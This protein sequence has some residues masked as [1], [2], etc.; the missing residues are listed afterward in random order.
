MQCSFDSSSNDLEYLLITYSTPLNSAA[1]SK[2]LDG[3]WTYS[4]GPRQVLHYA[5]FRQS[6]RPSVTKASRRRAE[7][8]RAQ[9]RAGRGRSIEEGPSRREAL[10]ALDARRQKV[11][12][13]PAPRHPA[14]SR[15]CRVKNRLS[16]RSRTAG[17]QEE[18]R[19]GQGWSHAGDQAGWANI[20]VRIRPNLT[21]P[22]S[23]AVQANGSKRAE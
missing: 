15:Q 19:T 22:G 10:D 16:R 5:P 18:L 17:G 9:G 1:A 6:A 14:H 4:A 13:L 2:S 12:L 8:K 7:R 20:V 23:L 21:D 3:N 11:K